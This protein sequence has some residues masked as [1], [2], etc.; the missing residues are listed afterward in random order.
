MSWTDIST[1]DQ[2]EAVGTHLDN[3]LQSRVSVSVLHIRP[4]HRSKLR[5]WKAQ[6]KRIGVDRILD[7]AADD[8]NLGLD[9]V[10][11][12]TIEI[13]IAINSV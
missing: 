12:R 6:G 11:S 10:S 5:I 4:N 8:D 9:R 2:L 1:A 3:H 13:A 7:V